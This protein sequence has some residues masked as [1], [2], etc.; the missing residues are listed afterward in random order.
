MTTTATAAATAARAAA[1]LAQKR[2]MAT[3]NPGAAP[4]FPRQ[5][6]NRAAEK[7]QKWVRGNQVRNQELIF[8]LRLE[9]T[10]KKKSV[11]FDES[12]DVLRFKSESPRFVKTVEALCVYDLRRLGIVMYRWLTDRN[13]DVTYDTFEM[14]GYLRSI[15]KKFDNGADVVA[16]NAGV[17]LPRSYES[18]LR[19]FLDLLEQRPIDEADG[20]TAPVSR[21]EI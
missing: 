6:R 19:K 20:P 10:T 14:I 18:K 2:R 16:F 7:I 13:C 1:A 21:R 5:V 17:R 3:L 9:N 11:Q 12:V 4:F 15:L 8:M